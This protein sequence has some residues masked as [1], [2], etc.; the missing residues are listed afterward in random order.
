[1]TTDP[2]LDASSPLTLLTRELFYVSASLSA[3]I[4]VELRDD[5]IALEQPQLMSLGIILS[6][7]ECYDLTITPTHI[8]ILDDD[9][10]YSV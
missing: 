10:T 3:G 4:E 2:V 8:T 9:G 5:I 6:S 7:T 1:M